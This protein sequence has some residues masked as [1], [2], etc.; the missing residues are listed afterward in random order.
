[1]KAEQRSTNDKTEAWRT[2]KGEDAERGRRRTGKIEIRYRLAFCSRLNFH[3]SGRLRVVSPALDLRFYSRTLRV[4]EIFAIPCRT[5][6]V[7]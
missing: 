4:L 6:T 7:S 2:E 5:A 1:M 3:G